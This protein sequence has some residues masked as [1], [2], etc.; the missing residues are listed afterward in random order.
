[1]L[2]SDRKRNY[3]PL[4]DLEQISNRRQLEEAKEF[5]EMQAQDQNNTAF[6]R[7]SQNEDDFDDL[8]D[9][10]ESLQGGDNLALTS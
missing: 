3:I 2:Q 7:T 5:Q 8:F 1:M 9:K 4:D 6:R 10:P